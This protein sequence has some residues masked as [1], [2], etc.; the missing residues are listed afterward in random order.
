MIALMTDFGLAGPYVGQIH[1]VLA[2][3]A[4][5][6]PVINL[7]H[8]IPAF[9]ITSAAGLIPAY[10]L[11]LPAESV[12]V[13]VVD[14]TVG[15]PRFRPVAL[16]ADGRWFVGPDNGQFDILLQH[17]ELERYHELEVDEARVSASF[18][19]RDVYAPAAA[20]LA[21]GD[22]CPGRAAQRHGAVSELP[23]DLPEVVYIDHFGNAIT[24]LR[25]STLTADAKLAANGVMFPAAR[26][27]A[28]VPPGEGFWYVNSNGLAEL[29]VNQG[30]AAERGSLG[31]GSRVSVEP[32]TARR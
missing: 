28:S 20:C 24:G 11:R 27:F 2:V 21:R 7:V 14:P 31:V 6:V 4:P 17:V 26:T 19:G 32:A 13:C 29:A 10:A 9:S 18:H 15:T 5:G 23:A 25:G 1:A 16:R 3:E 8:D 22:A 30:S 12:T